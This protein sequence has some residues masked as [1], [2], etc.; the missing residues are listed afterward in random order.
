MSEEKPLP[1][2]A[3]SKGRIY[4]LTKKGS[5]QLIYETA[6]VTIED[7]SHEYIW[8]GLSRDICEL[9]NGNILIQ[10]DAG[11]PEDFIRTVD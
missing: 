8:D 11:I 1:F 9:L 2:I 3:D 4:R 6:V 7:D 10:K 5:Y